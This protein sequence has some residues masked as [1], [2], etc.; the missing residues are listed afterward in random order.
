VNHVT[1][2]AIVSHRARGKRKGVSPGAAARHSQPESIR[3]V[4]QQSF[5]PKK[6]TLCQQ[7]W[8]EPG[9][10]WLNLVWWAQNVSAECSHLVNEAHETIQAFFSG[11]KLKKNLQVFF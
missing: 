2:E 3:T 8:V 7:S 10:E 1:H 4:S 9:V 5:S 11:K 6:T